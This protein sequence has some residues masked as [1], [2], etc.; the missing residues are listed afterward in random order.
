MKQV[1]TLVASLVGLSPT[2]SFADT[3]FQQTLFSCTFNEGINSV[4]VL[5]VPQDENLVYT[6]ANAQGHLELNLNAPV[7]AVD[8]APFSWDHGDI[9]ERVTFYN[10]DTSYQVFSTFSPDSYEIA[11]EIYSYEITAG[12]TVTSPSGQRT[13]LDCD[14]FS[15][16][17]ATPL[18]GLGQIAVLRDASYDHFS[19][20]LSSNRPYASCIGI[21]SAGC[22]ADCLD[23]KVSLWQDILAET[24]ATTRRM[25]GEGPGSSTTIDHLQSLWEASRDA[26]CEASAWTNYNVMDGEAG[27]KSCII[28]YTAQRVDFLRRMQAG[29]EFDG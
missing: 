23:F 26:D 27:L 10:G 9:T 20:C 29:L 22:V 7:Q 12:V 8:Y 16:N 14:T 21:P 2:S 19:E 6:Y 4:Q 1:M 24:L 11:G 28:D 5:Y 13:E 17:P 15:I 25:V 18:G 3:S